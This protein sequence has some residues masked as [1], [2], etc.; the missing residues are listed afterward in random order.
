MGVGLTAGTTDGVGLG[1]KGGSVGA[2]NSGETG[3]SVAG[4][5]WLPGAGNSH[6]AKLSSNRTVVTNN[7]R[8]V[9]FTR[10]LQ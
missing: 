4:G 2:P 3:V 7:K 1:K 6:A 5:G 9:R 10:G 8:L